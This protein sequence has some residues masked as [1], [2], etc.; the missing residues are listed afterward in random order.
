MSAYPTRTKVKV[1]RA[2]RRRKAPKTQNKIPL[3]M[4][5]R[6]PFSWSTQLAKKLPGKNIIV[7]AEFVKNTAISET[8]NTFRVA[9]DIGAKV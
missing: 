4:P 8:L 5:T 7:A 1:W 6:V 9:S 2:K 3:N